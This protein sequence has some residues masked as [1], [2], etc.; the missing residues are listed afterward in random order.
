MLR[1][2]IAILGA[3]NIGQTMA[4]DLSLAGYKVNLYQHHFFEESFKVV[5]E[6]REL[7]LTGVGRQGRARIHKVTMD[8]KDA[9][10][11]PKLILLT[12]ASSGHELFFNTMIPY[13]K[14]GQIVVIMTGNFGSLRLG[15]LL[16]DKAP[17]RRVT[18]YE[19]NTMPY[20]TRVVSPGK[21]TTI[22]A[23]GPGYNP[24]ARPPEVAHL[25]HLLYGSALP[26]KDTNVAFEEL[27]ELFPR[28]SPAQNVIATALNNPNH[29]LHPIGSLLN[30]GRIEYSKGNFYLYREGVTPSVLSVMHAVSNEMLA[31][32]KT[33]TDKSTPPIMEPFDAMMAPLIGH[34]GRNAN[35]LGPTSLKDR[36]VTEDV[37]Y[38][39]VPDSELAK[40]AGVATPTIDAMIDIAS[41]ACQEDYRKTGRT[42]ETL[43][44][45]DLKREEIISLVNG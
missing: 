8:M 43:G 16:G 18:I 10:S 13:L 44:L 39:L 30:T 9:L 45:A 29:C 24:E 4:A 14:D 15:R 3:G 20:G 22:F 32:A 1:Q 36:Y 28:L 19:I 42:L 6:T 35:V 27:R 34:K 21:V 33:Y 5:L 31:V 37:P 23:T 7:E 11:D 17:D 12:V 38:G 41:V 40:K 26:A 2:P 25:P